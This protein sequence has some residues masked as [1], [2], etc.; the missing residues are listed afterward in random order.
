MTDDHLAEKLHELKRR[1][2]APIA[3]IEMLDALLSLDLCLSAQQKR[4]RFYEIMARALQRLKRKVEDK[5]IELET[6]Y[7]MSNGLTFGLNGT[8]LDARILD[9][10]WASSL[11]GS[12][13]KK[14]TQGDGQTKSRWIRTQ[15]GA[16]T[17][18]GG[19]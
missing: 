15:N 17:K 12:G 19:I 16:L 1:N 3:L 4:K 7:R 11:P 8:Y 2:Q 6:T 5:G 10:K 9:R 18:F 14:G 13:L